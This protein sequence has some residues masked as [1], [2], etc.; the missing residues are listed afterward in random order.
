MGGP[1][2]LAKSGVIIP[3]TGCMVTSRF[4]DGGNQLYLD[5]WVVTGD[6]WYPRYKTPTTLLVNRSTH[7]S[8]E[9]HAMKP[10]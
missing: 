3:G 9:R 2:S 4:T 7:H 6:P 10:D 1:S 8:I 5:Y